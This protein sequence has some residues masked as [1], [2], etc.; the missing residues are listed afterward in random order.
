MF[1]SLKT[2]AIRYLVSFAVCMG[3]VLFVE[4]RTSKDPPLIVN[5][6]QAE[7]NKD[8]V[9]KEK[10]VT[11]VVKPDGTTKEI[12]VE[13][14]KIVKEKIKKHDKVSVQAAAVKKPQ[15]SVGVSYLPSLRDPPSIKDVEIEAGFRVS[16]SNFWLV[17][18]Y[19]VKYNQ[20][21]V[22]LRYEF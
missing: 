12:V 11:K 10:I 20:L 17:S 1:N 2:E 3:V 8:V 7:V 15:Y 16:S 9:I 14:E 18:G 21:T 4:A 19:A 22:G 13:R 6:H 5:E